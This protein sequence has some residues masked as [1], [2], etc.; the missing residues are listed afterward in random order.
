MSVKPGAFL[1]ETDGCTAARLSAD[2]RSP[3]RRAH[4]AAPLRC[5]TTV[6]IT[7]L[8]ERVMCTGMLLCAADDGETV[9]NANET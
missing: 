8:V 1:R 4:S 9:G 6:S 3:G 2:A 5:E 7:R